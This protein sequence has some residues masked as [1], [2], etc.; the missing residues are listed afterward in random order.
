M[1]GTLNQSESCTEVCGGVQRWAEVCTEVHR[2][3]LGGPLLY[4]LGNHWLPL[5]TI[6]LVSDNR[7]FDI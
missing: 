6:D 2:G 1:V 7:E 5:A 4:I 3:V